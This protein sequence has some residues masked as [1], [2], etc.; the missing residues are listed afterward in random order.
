MLR[1][2]A[3]DTPM[4]RKPDQL[5]NREPLAKADLS[6]GDIWFYASGPRNT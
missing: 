2:M 6:G 4:S 1:F 3:T 5:E